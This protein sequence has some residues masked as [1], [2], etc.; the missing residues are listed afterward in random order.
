MTDLY[1]IYIHKSIPTLISK[2]I[3]D[4]NLYSGRYLKLLEEDFEK[5]FSKKA[6]CFSNF[7]TGFNSIFKVLGL[8]TD[9]EILSTPI[10]CMSSFQPLKASKLNIK[11]VDVNPYFGSMDPIDLKKKINKNSKILH[12]YSWGGNLGL[13]EE[14]IKVGKEANLIIILDGLESFGSSL[15]DKLLGIQ[16]EIDFAIF[17]LRSIRYPSAIDGSF[18]LYNSN[19][20]YEKSCRVRDL[21]IDRKSFR[22]KNGEINPENDI[23]EISLDGIMSEINAMTAYLNLSDSEMIF[24]KQKFNGNFLKSF[25]VDE[26]DVRP[27]EQLN[28]NPN[29][30]VFSFLNEDEKLVKFLNEKQIQFS[31]LHNRV[32]NYSIFS[33]SKVSLQG[34]DKFDNEI[35][36]IPSGWWVDK[37]NYLN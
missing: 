25:L 20:D 10:G 1:K 16:K 13:I 15:G 33:S 12:L 30:W 19:D 29:Y 27:L 22:L 32:D 35:L 18:V 23:S 36:N 14:L 8:S 11:W 6:L 3:N 34:L 4:K 31:K 28:G 21:G 2:L 7:Y 37:K 26:F 24:Q 9:Y 5:R 17:S